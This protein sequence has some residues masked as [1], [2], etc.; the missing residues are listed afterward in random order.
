LIVPDKKAL[1]KK[2]EGIEVWDVKRIMEE[3]KEKYLK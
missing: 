3:L 1:E 2:P